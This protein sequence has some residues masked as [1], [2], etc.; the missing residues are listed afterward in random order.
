MVG[1]SVFF[2]YLCSVIFKVV[3]LLGALMVCACTQKKEEPV[4]T[5]WGEIQ[6]TIPQSN[7]FDLE[8]IQLLPGQE[9]RNIMV[10]YRMTEGWDE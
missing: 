10:H 6:D 8:D 7:N 4:V 5:P 1:Q 9:A 3:I 2:S